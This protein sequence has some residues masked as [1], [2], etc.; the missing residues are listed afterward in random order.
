M[1]NNHYLE[2]YKQISLLLTKIDKKCKNFANTE[3]NPYWGDLAEV[4][5]SLTEVDTFLNDDLLIVKK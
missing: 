2:Q 1:E 5:E 3:P 4:I